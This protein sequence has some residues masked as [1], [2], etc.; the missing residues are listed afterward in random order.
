MLFPFT[1][2]LYYRRSNIR[3]DS[4]SKRFTLFPETSRAGP[5]IVRP[6][7]TEIERNAL[8]KSARTITLGNF[9]KEDTSRRAFDPYH[10]KTYT[11]DKATRKNHKKPGLS[12]L[13][14]DP[15]LSMPERSNIPANRSRQGL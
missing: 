8:E 12:T 4:Q 10:L 2:Y 5:A 9:M 1:A 13:T 15:L 14:D 6:T 7:K 3:D 11:K